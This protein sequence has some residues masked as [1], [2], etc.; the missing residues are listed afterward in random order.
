MCA[1]RWSPVPSG[2]SKSV[3]LPFLSPERL[4][5]L[6]KAFL[7]QSDTSDSKRRDELASLRTE[8]TNSTGA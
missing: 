6:L 8:K 5:K 7:E 2:V 4:P 1:A 3:R